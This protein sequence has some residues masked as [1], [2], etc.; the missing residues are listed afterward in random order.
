MVGSTKPAGELLG[1]YEIIECLVRGD[2]AELLL[3]R[4]AGTH[5]VIKRLRADAGAASAELFVA[6][7][8]LAQTLVHPNLGRVLDVGQHHDVPYLVAEYLHG[9]DLRH[10]LTRAFERNVKVP[11]EH[12]VA[13]VRSAAAGLH[14]AHEQNGSDDK[15]LGI[16]HRDVSP[17]NI[18]V[19]YD[20]SVKVVDVGVVRAMPSTARSGLR[21]KAPYMSPEQCNGKKL[22]RRSDLFSLGTVLYELITGRRLFKASSE[23]LTMAAVVGGKVPPPSAQ[24]TDL[25]KALAEIA[26]RTLAVDPTARIATAQQLVDALDGLALASTP[27]ALAAYMT[28]MFGERPM[29]WTAPGTVPSRVHVDFDGKGTGLAVPPADALKGVAATRG[30]AI[31][32]SPI[33][34]AR[35]QL[36]VPAPVAAA[37]S[38]PVMIPG[39]APSAAASGDRKK[40]TTRAP[41]PAPKRAR[42]KTIQIPTTATRP[43]AAQVDSG[44]G[45]PAPESNVATGSIDTSPLVAPPT[46]EAPAP[47]AA[48]KAD[49]T[50]IP[51]VVKKAAITPTAIAAVAA[52]PVVRTP[53]TGVPAVNAATK[54]ISRPI[55]VPQQLPIVV[56]GPDVQQEPELPAVSGELVAATPTAPVFVAAVE[57]VESPLAIVETEKRRHN[58]DVV[59]PLPAPRAPTVQSTGNPFDAS[60][61]FQPG[62]RRLWLPVAVAGAV[63]L[64]LVLVL[65]IGLSG[66]GTDE[67]LAQPAAIEP[68]RVAPAPAFEPERTWASS[69]PPAPEPAVVEPT[70]VAVEPVVAQPVAVEPAPVAKPAVAKPARK[71]AVVAKPAP[72]KPVSIAR[73]ARKPAPT[74][75]ATRPPVKPVA[76]PKPVAKKPVT[77]P[78]RTAPVKKSSWDP[79]SLF[80][81]R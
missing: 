45:D 4:A 15:P 27:A 68:V 28:E 77:K 26:R 23:Y 72:K 75:V 42:P 31:K 12:I 71:P 24:R 34:T 63:M 67:A 33:E 66:D 46:P 70:P 41:V 80:P 36:A 9:E 1:R 22:D 54:P 74:T 32:A 37:P 3:A 39:G 78:V 48:A 14:H 11:I 47:V 2:M 38:A 55:A 44:W 16:V 76:R 20:G 5:V 49:P 53:P 51:S 25:P 57:S 13:I 56:A 52:K 62:A 21:D 69:P 40:P 8:R 65:A 10:L 61:A 19:G 18:L 35:A 29:P 58:T 7:A 43:T 30:S 79:D 81:K 17:T 60:V 73:P 59:I 6:E 64:A 50:P